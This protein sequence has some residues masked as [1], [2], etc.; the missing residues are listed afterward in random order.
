MSFVAQQHT[1]EYNE[2]RIAG[3]E[4]D[5]KRLT[6]EKEGIGLKFKG[7]SDFSIKA[8]PFIAK[9]TK[10]WNQYLKAD[11]WVTHYKTYDFGNTDKNYIKMELQISIRYRDSIRHLWFEN[12]EQFKKNG[13]ILS[14]FKVQCYTLEELQKEYQ[15]T[16]DYYLEIKTEYDSIT[17]DIKDLTIE[18]SNLITEL[19]S[20]GIHH[21]VKRQ[22]LEGCWLIVF[23]NYKSQITVHKE[24]GE[25]VG[26][27]TVNNLNGYVDGQEM[28]RVDR[29]T[30]DSFQ[31][32]EFTW[33][34][35]KNENGIETYKKKTIP[36]RITI[37][38]D[39]NFL[40]WISDQTV[41]M[42]RCN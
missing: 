20:M 18:R 22:D 6:Y 29:I 8:R 39:G 16:A 38:S 37:S 11:D 23:G 25:Y 30:S 21:Y 15:R 14:Y 32:K 3:I 40:N 2:N 24:Y 36:A 27:L 41:T 10:Y 34:K 42:S 17:S 12:E 28:F 9:N 5:L 35:V 31:G 19:S 4:Y 7:I 33:E 13:G 1:R 26:V